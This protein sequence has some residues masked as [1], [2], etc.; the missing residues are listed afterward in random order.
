M[1]ATIISLAIIVIVIIT[2]TATATATTILFFCLDPARAL[3][4]SI[5]EV[6]QD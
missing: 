3:L 4:G 1:G 5:S 6:R 2:A